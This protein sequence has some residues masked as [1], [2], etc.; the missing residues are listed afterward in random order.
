MPFGFRA[1]AIGFAATFFHPDDTGSQEPRRI[2]DL[3][4]SGKGVAFPFRLGHRG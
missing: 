4:Q 3:T 2:K 1:T